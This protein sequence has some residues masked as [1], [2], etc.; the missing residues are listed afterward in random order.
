MPISGIH[1]GVSKMLGF[2]Q[3]LK[4]PILW[5]FVFTILGFFKINVG[6]EIWATQEGLPWVRISNGKPSPITSAWNG[7]K[8]SRCFETGLLQCLFGSVEVSELR[9]RDCS[10][11]LRA[12]M[13]TDSH[14][15][16][17]KIVVSPLKLPKFPFF[18][19]CWELIYRYPVWIMVQLP[20]YATWFNWEISGDFSGCTFQA[21][22]LKGPFSRS[23]R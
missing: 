18:V 8:P 11:L 7:C 9:G 14:K 2:P 3:D 21:A 4:Q 19:G 22:S 13:S 1:V 16:V 17:D 6:R 10:K 20:C 5:W 23:N 12:L 15:E